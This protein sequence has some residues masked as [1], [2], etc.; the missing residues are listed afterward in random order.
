MYHKQLI[1]SAEG[2][3]PGDKKDKK[4]DSSD[5]DEARFQII[6]CSKSNGQEFLTEDYREEKKEGAFFNNMSEAERKLIESTFGTNKEMEID[7]HK[8]EK[9]VQFGY[10]KTYILQSL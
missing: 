4:D 8:V 1:N 6:Q 9:L 3:T 7:D 10:P 2:D 5:E